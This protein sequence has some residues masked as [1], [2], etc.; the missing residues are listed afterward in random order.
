MKYKFEIEIDAPYELVIRLMDDPSLLSNW[1]PECIDHMQVNGEPGHVGSQAQVTYNMNGRPFE[2]T[3]TV[4]VRDLPNEYTSKFEAPGMANQVTNRFA[5]IGDASTYWQCQSEFVF[6]NW[7]MKLAGMFLGS[8]FRDQS[9]RYMN[10]FK[11]FAE[12]EYQ[13]ELSQL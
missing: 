13:R 3:K 2:M 10:L 9:W 7:L 6:T 8:A 1:Q 4:T 5:E 11:R 12:D